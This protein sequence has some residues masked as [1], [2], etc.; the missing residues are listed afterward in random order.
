MEYKTKAGGKGVENIHLYV[1]DQMAQLPVDF[2]LRGMEHIPPERRQQCRRYGRGL[3]K[4]NCIVASL[5]L[6]KG[7]AACFG[8]TQLPPLSRNP[9]GKP[10]FAYSPHIFFNI[11]HCKTAVVCAIATQQIGVDVECFR[12]FNRLVA[13]KVC[14]ADELTLLDNEPDPSRLFCTLWTQKESLAKQVGT[15]LRHMLQQPVTPN[16]T[17]ATWTFASHT[18]TVC[19]GAQTNA[20]PQLHHITAAELLASS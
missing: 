4:R 9:F 1:F 20:T 16:T 6:Q 13:Q 7:L 3:D 5:L 11:S 8:I 2:V 10:Y 12:P 19:Y 15:G 17:F 14:T 18:I